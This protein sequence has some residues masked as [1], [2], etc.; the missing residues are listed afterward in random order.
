MKRALNRWKNSIKKRINRLRRLRGK[1]VDKEIIHFIHIGKTGGSAIKYVLMN[2]KSTPNCEIF[3]YGHAVGL[4]NIK[5]GDRV[6]FFLRDPIKRFVSAFYGR[7]REDKPRYYSPWSDEEKRAFKIFKTPNELALALSSNDEKLK[8]EAIRAMRGI[9]HIKN[10][11]WDWF[12]N[13]NYMLSR[14][15][16]IYFIGFQESLSSDFEKLKVKLNLPD[17][18]KLPTDNINAHKNPQNVDKR[19]D[20]KAI[21]NLKEWYKRDY[22]F[23]EFCKANFLD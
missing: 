8:Q 5:R 6:I 7:Q 19:L 22:E 20:A 21:E 12:C 9:A 2:Y 4:M 15:R 11:Y 1:L 10:S 16:D 13:E 3:F 18:A 17:E 23:I 14:K